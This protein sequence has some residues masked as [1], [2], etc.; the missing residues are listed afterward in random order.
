MIRIIISGGGTGGHVFPAI[1]IAQ[2]ICRQEPDSDILFVGAEGRMEMEKVPAAGFRIEGLPVTGFQRRLTLSNLAFPFRLMKSMIR[3]K[4]I[5]KSFDPD[6]VIGVGGY[7]SGPILRVASGMGIPTLIQEQNS[8]PG[9]TNRMLARSASRICVAYEGM[10][11][12]F[13]SEKIVLTGNPVRNDIESAAVSRSE[14]YRHFNLDPAKKTILVVGG[15]LGAR[16]INEAISHFITSE[17]FRERRCQLLWQTGKYYHEAIKT[18][19]DPIPEGVTLLPFIDRMDMAYSSADLIISRA[20]AIAI[21]ELYLVGKPAILIPSPNVAEDHQT[22]NARALENRGAALLIRDSDAVAT[23]GDII[24][25]AL[26]NADLLTSLSF[27]IRQMA[28]PG[29]AAKIAGE[30]LGL[31]VRKRNP[32][33]NVTPPPA[34]GAVYLLGI[35]GI[36]MSA[37]ARYYHTKGYLVS[38]Y[39]RTPSALTGELE[40]EGIS[41]HYSEDIRKI[42]PNPD[43]IIYT[44]AIPSDHAELVQIRKD[45]LPLKKRAEVLGMITSGYRTIAVAGTHGKTSTSSMITH[46]LVTA[47]IPVLAFLGGISKNYR[48]NFVYEHNGQSPSETWCVAEADEYDRSFLHL[49]PH[50]AIITSTDADHLDI[51]GKHD[52][53]L[54]SFEDFTTRIKPGGELILKSG[55]GIAPVRNSVYYVSGYQVKGEATFSA[56]NIRM[57][58]GLL[59]FDFLHPD[60]MITDLSLQVPGLFNLE[61]A[62]AALAVGI[63]LGISVQDLRRAFSSYLGVR[64]RFEFVVKQ[65]DCV[66]IDDYAHHPEE[67]RACISAARDLYPGKKITGIFQP[68]LYSRTRDLADG[69]AQSLSMLDRIWLLEIYPARELPIEGVT[70]RV[71]LDKITLKDKALISSEQLPELLAEQKPE[72][73]ITLGAGDIDRLVEPIAG[74]LTNR[75]P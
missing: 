52:E 5:V 21:S 13:P 47:K 44:P 48:T 10:S 38:G 45:N 43:M 29:A 40:Q 14:A 41:I 56:N 15:S 23:L 22:K 42:P 65:P 6:I 24:N 26:E 69:F 27:N 60:G 34:T 4:Q 25:S 7:A 36:G 73:L 17:K 35:G 12:F 50:I 32:V 64:R 54:R 18:R 33:S 59:Y 72:V 68:H 20:G 63:K 8:F 37:L 57:A 9:I 28:M 67:L 19:H 30:A 46:M 51:Y 55:T 58:E 11:E 2:A 66:Y 70:S 16:T 31:A 74:I 62:V 75:R 3:A 49:S 39:D 61:N 1:A 53:M 71:I